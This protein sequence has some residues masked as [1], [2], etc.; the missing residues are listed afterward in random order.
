MHRYGGKTLLLQQLVKFNRVFDLLHKYNNLVEHEGIEEVS[1]FPDLLVVI[2]L[3]IELLESV[4]GEL[5]LVV[6]ED[7]E[8][9]L[10]KFSADLFDVGRHGR[11]EHHDLLLVRGVLEDILD[12]SSHV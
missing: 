11:G 3:H 7:F 4:K 8:L 9:V 1:E 6:N 10:H 12:V 2:N 5:S